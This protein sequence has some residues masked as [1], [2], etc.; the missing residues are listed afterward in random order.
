[1]PEPIVTA[2]PTAAIIVPVGGQTPIPVETVEPAPEE[3]AALV[4]PAGNSTIISG[5]GET[6]TPPSDETPA[7][8]VT[9]TSEPLVVTETPVPVVVDET[10]TPPIS[11]I[12]SVPSG[13]D[14]TSTPTAEPTFVEPTATIEPTAAIVVTGTEDIEETPEPVPPTAGP[15]VGVE[16]TP[17]PVETP[18]PEETR[19]PDEPIAGADET[20]IAEETALPEEPVETPEPASGGD[21]VAELPGDASAAAGGSVAVTRDGT[22][23]FE[24]GAGVVIV[25]AGSG[26][27]YGLGLG[28][29]PI[30]GP[31]GASLLVTAVDDAT[32]NQT[33]AVWDRGSGNISYLGASTDL[34]FRDQPAGWDGSVF[35][36]QRVYLD[37][38]G[39]IELRRANVDGSGDEVVWSSQD[40]GVGAFDANV[41]RAAIGGR[42][43]AFVNG[44]QLFVASR[45]DAGNA[46]AV[47]IGGAPLDI[48]W[49]P[50]GSSL[51]INDGVS[52][53]LYDAGGAVLGSATNPNGW[54][55]GGA[56]WTGEG[57]VY[58]VYE[59]P[60]TVRLLPIGAFT[61]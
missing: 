47:P 25:D 48:A 10:P 5:T 18:L 52:I 13:P 23:A 33:I 7:A 38:S 43:L 37:D 22:L 51:A 35:Y 4:T 39:V 21:V 26:Q 16:Q 40:A 30:W 36:Y 59:D 6:P 15:I 55:I 19:T 20:P 3:T 45:N 57:V 28:A 56:R 32:G 12:T 2:T 31:Q 44:G 1:V 42:Q 11:V 46:V 41:S 49:S 58:V 27:V 61:G 29:S 54:Q 9:S 24:G 14:A 53:T 50:D 60:P 17:P 34:P 8:F